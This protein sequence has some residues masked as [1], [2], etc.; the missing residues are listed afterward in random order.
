MQRAQRIVGMV[1]VLGLLAGAG[2][3]FAFA[4][5]AKSSTHDIKGADLSGAL[6]FSPGCDC[7]SPTARFSITLNRQ[8]NLDVT[9]VTAR[10]GRPVRALLVDSDRNGV[11][12]LVWDGRRDDRT[13]AADGAYRVRVR[14]ARQR[15]FLIP[16]QILL[17]T[18]APTVTATM[19]L[20]RTITYGADGETG[21]YSFTVTTDEPARVR[22]AVYAVGVDGAI[23]RV[24]YPAETVQAVP[25]TPAT[26][27][28]SGAHE[29]PDR[30]AAPGTY[31]VGY[32]AI[33]AAS[34]V[35]RAPTAFTPGATAPAT[36][37]RVQTIEIDG[38]GGVHAVAAATVRVEYR[39][40]RTGLPGVRR[41][42]GSGPPDSVDVHAPSL[43]G[44]YAMVAYGSGATA[45]SHAEVADGARRVLV[46]PTYTWQWRNTYDAG[47]DGFPDA[48]P[49]ALSLDRPLGDAGRRELDQLLRD[50][51]PFARSTRPWGAVT[52]ERLESAGVPSRAR[53][54]VIVGERVWTP[55]LLDRL[56][57]F[58]RH[59][60][61]IVLIASPLD[62]RALL[63][64]GAITV[65]PIAAPSGLHGK[66]VS[67]R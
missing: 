50:A 6:A 21:A 38:H 34:N 42:Q 20:G 3:A 35:T 8:A 46:V 22:A 63:D 64:A 58:L 36:P 44:L 5:A 31:L 16:G 37:V 62:R 51:A 56:R 19:P 13:I 14:F 39:R 49:A 65:D 48:P 40:V 25:G 60:G 15:S 1:L 10:T 33:D 67:S 55:G 4:Q 12:G 24:W 27:T 2:I 53:E 30:A 66:R 43:P 41:A 32:E 7:A 52:D 47:L 28:W 11:V 26:L 23:A 57:V 18:K 54:L 29:T 9:I 61:R 17:D 59:R 45:W